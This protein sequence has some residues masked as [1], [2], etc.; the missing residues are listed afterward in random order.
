[1]TILSV[2]HVT[3]YQVLA[4]GQP[5]TVGQ[6]GLVNMTRKSSSAHFRPSSVKTTDLA[7]FTGS[8][9][10]PLSWSRLRASQSK[11]F[12]AASGRDG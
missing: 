6:S 10:M 12:H 8:A 4:K 7:L 2:R 3:N 1:M 11:P 5:C 9:I